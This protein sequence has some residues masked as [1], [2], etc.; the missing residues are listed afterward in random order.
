MPNDELQPLDV[1]AVAKVLN[2]NIEAE[3]EEDSLHDGWVPPAVIRDTAV[4]LVARFGIAKPDAPGMTV[5]ELGKAIKDILDDINRAITERKPLGLKPLILP[6]IV[7]GIASDIAIHLHP[8]LAA[9]ATGG[10]IT[11][12]DCVWKSPTA[13]SWSRLIESWRG[14]YD[15]GDFAICWEDYVSQRLADF[16]PRTLNIAPRTTGVDR[17]KMEE[18]IVGILNGFW[19]D[20]MTISEA[21]DAI[22][23][24][25]EGGAK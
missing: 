1:G 12:R 17:E 2:D 24:L 4:A 10:G 25:L 6:T 9:R 13:W 14:E 21:T 7:D 8:L 5:E 22:L 20:T 18:G 11:I 23:A 19:R 3:C 16:I 15:K